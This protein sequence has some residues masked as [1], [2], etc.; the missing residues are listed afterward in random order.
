M[1]ANLRIAIIE[2]S[3]I[4]RNGLSN[5]LR[6]LSGLSVSVSEILENESLTESLRL[7]KPD[8]LGPYGDYFAYVTYQKNEEGFYESQYRYLNIQTG[9]WTGP[10]TLQDSLG[11]QIVPQQVLGDRFCVIAG[12]E[13]MP[14][15]VSDAENVEDADIGL[16]QYALIRQQ[17]FMNSVPNYQMIHMEMLF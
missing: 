7:H 8:I 11:H 10:V 2:P 4:I 15:P 14:V 3:I 5:L 1:N 9:D 12:Y 13:T 6:K 16:P 17:D